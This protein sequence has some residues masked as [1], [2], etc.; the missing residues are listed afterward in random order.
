MRLPFLFNSVF[1]TIMRFLILHLLLYAHLVLEAVHFGLVVFTRNVNVKKKPKKT[2]TVGAEHTVVV[3]I[4]VVVLVCVILKNRVSVR[5]C[6]R[7]WECLDVL[8]HERV[9]ISSF[10]RAARVHGSMYSSNIYKCLF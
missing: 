9:F 3:R 8:M 10:P 5:A 1:G 4:T 6:S 7:E 2:A